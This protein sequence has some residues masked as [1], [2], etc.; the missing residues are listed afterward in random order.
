MDN[1]WHLISLELYCESLL[2]CLSGISVRL[3]LMMQML[4]FSLWIPNQYLNNVLESSCYSL[5]CTVL[6][7]S[8]WATVSH[9]LYLLYPV[10]L[11]LPGESTE[12]LW[13]SIIMSVSKVELSL[14]GFWVLGRN[15]E[16]CSGLRYKDAYGCMPTSSS[17]VIMWW[18]Y[19]IKT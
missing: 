1:K 12:H 19:S 5:N 4:D 11:F 15:L 10:Y 17:A 9:K 13:A 14:I 8:V 16:G 6:W 18:L 3:M 7:F 2:S